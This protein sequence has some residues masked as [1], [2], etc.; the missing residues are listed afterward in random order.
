MKRD[1]S[2]GSSDEVLGLAVGV[3]VTDIRPVELGA[4]QRSR[5]LDRV[6]ALAPTTSPPD[7]VTRRAEEVPW[8]RVSPFIEMRV[9]VRDKALGSQTLMLRMRAGGQLPAH[10]HEQLE[11]F[12]VLEGE[13]HIGTH[14]LGA[15]DVHVAQPGSW[16]DVVT[17]RTG[18]TVLIR[19]EYPDP[20][21]RQ[22]SGR[23]GG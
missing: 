13:C 21:Q 4:E 2:T 15:G 1:T 17:T 18:V 12:L 22:G 3:F 8:I 6:L 23:A 14:R 5:M 9:L 19:G 20:V 7:T 16:H 11:E 10:R